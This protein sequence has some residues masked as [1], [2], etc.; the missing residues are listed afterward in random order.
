MPPETVAQVT[1]ADVGVRL[2]ETVMMAVPLDSL[3]T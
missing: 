1:E 2:R 3:V